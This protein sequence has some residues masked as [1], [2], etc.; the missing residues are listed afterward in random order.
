MNSNAVLHVAKKQLALEDEDYRAVLER[1]TGKRSSRDMSPAERG[2]VLDEFKRMGFEVVARSPHAP[3]VKGQ[4]ER[5]RRVGGALVLTG[6]YVPKIRALWLSAY[7]LGIMRDRSDEALAAFARRQ[8]GIDHVDWVRDPR[9]AAKVIE[10]LKA[11]MA[12][13]AGVVWPA[14]K[15]A[16]PHES[17]RAVIAA[18][19]RILGVAPVDLAKVFNLDGMIAELGAQIRKMRKS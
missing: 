10:A 4:E 17:K 8:T 3:T 19:V 11:K 6:P 15:A 1:I 12:R 14:A 7:N 9:D 13:D 18:Q 2:K 5:G 16:L